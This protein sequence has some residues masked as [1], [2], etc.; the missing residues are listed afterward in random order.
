MHRRL[1][2]PLL[3]ALAC[4]V[5]GLGLAQGAAASLTEYTVPTEI[6]SPGGITAGPDGAL[7]FTESSWEANQIGRITTGGAFTE[8]GGLSA[9]R[10][11]Y[12][13]PTRITSGPDRRLWFTEFDANKIGAITTGGIL[14]EYSTGLTPGAG[15]AG[16]T[17]GPDGRLWFTEFNV[18]K[19]A[20][21]TTTGTITEYPLSASDAAPSG[22]T[23]GPDG[24]L[25]FTERRGLG[26]IT[27]EGTSTLKI[28]TPDYARPGAITSAGGALWFTQNYYES[29][30]RLDVDN[31][32]G[33]TFGPA[34]YSSGLAGITVGPDGA[35]WFTDTSGFIGRMT[36]DGFITNEIHLPTLYSEPNGIASGPDGAVWFTEYGGRIGRLTTDVPPPPTVEVKLAV[37]PPSDPNRFELL[38]GGQTK[39]SNAG[40]GDTTGKQPVSIL[41]GHWI[42][43]RGPLANYSI[44]ITCKDQGGSGATVA[45]SAEYLVYVRVPSESDIVCTVVNARRDPPSNFSVSQRS[46][47][48]QARW[49]LPP[50]PPTMLTGFLEFSPTP[51][52]YPDGFFSDPA[53]VAYE[54]DSPDEEFDSS[55]ETFPPGTYYVH[56]SSYDADSCGTGGSCQDRF[57]SPPVKLVVPPPP[58]I[59]PAP[60]ASRSAVADKVTA[61]SAWVVRPRQKLRK[62]YVKAAMGERGTIS[63][64]GRV[65]VAGS[66][67]SYRLATVFA[68][69]VPGTNVRLHL[70]LAAKAFKAVRS[71][72]KRHKKATAKITITATDSAGNVKR[73]QRAVALRL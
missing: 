47:T 35:V 10:Q 63:V 34:L 69:A 46:G 33:R 56:V 21:I 11:Y 52:T 6:G 61:F 54:F 32:S 51:D 40:N 14:T 3:G 19:I 41:D 17:V 23:A 20:A 24:A 39:K 29:I 65:R 4:F 31:F 1:V 48:V 26:R 71:E 68:P 13:G 45:S 64:R 59:S 43:E 42:Q 62:L 53:T 27:T 5:S 57:S 30:G 60:P 15:P 49:T 9:P 22:I 12:S 28:D 37:S 18:G 58:S 73:E 7:W 36:T 72:L 67:R 44:S 55:P 25:W 8:F 66:P 38:I 70:K 50:P 16:I 2:L